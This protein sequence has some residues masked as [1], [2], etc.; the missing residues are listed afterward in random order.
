[1]APDEMLMPLKWRIRRKT[2]PVVESN[3]VTNEGSSSQYLFLTRPLPLLLQDEKSKPFRSDFP[4]N[5]GRTV[6]MR[7][8]LSGAK[9]MSGA[10]STM[11]SPCSDQYF[12]VILKFCFTV[13]H[14][15]SQYSGP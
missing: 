3:H 14:S 11:D 2:S 15:R 13:L 5:S 7:T 8:T 12:A 6:E 10:N 1:M 9:R 4:I